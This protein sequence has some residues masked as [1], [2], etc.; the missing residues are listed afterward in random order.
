MTVAATD[1][2]YLV[3]PFQ[4]MSLIFSNRNCI[5]SQGVPGFKGATDFGKFY[6]SAII[7]HLFGSAGLDNAHYHAFII[8]RITDDER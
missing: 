8:A 2:D 4:H 6:S 1:D 7:I 5:F 3:R